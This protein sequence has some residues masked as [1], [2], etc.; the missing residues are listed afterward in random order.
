[1]ECRFEVGQRVVCVTHGWEELRDDDSDHGPAHGE[2]CEIASI[3]VDFAGVWLVL[4]GYEPSYH[5]AGFR[6]LI[7]PDISVFTC[8]LEPLN[9]R[10]RARE[11]A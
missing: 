2:V 1:M 11:P 7:E 4:A 5:H 10:E 8:L 6:P 9:Q 3:E